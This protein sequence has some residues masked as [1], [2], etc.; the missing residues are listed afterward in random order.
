MKKLIDREHQLLSKQKTLQAE[1][2]KA[3]LSLGEDRQRLSSALKKDDIT[4]PQAAS[5][6][7][8]ASDEKL[9]LISE[10]LVRVTDELLI[11]QSKR[12]NVFSHA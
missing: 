3:Q 12:K 2:K 9:K 1:Q 8:R 5:V 4:D 11:I 6:S 7:I 10:E